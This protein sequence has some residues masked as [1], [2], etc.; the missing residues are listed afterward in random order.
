MDQEP[1]TLDV[2]NALIEWCQPTALIVTATPKG[3]KGSLE[4]GD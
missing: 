3:S 4:R 2:A 1:S